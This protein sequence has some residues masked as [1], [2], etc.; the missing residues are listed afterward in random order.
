MLLNMQ[1][2]VKN[3]II[4][5]ELNERFLKVRKLIMGFSV[6]HCTMMNRIRE[7]M[8]IKLSQ[9]MKLDENHSSL[10]PLSRTI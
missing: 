7:E 9:V 5:P 1:K 8:E 4:F 3:A 2:K 6:K 10:C